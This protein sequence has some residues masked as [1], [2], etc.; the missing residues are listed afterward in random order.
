MSV[1]LYG[2]PQQDNKLGVIYSTGSI[3]IEAVIAKDIP[4][5]A[6]YAIFETADLD[7]QLFDA[8]RFSDG[9]P[10]FNPE[11][12]KE[13][14][15]DLWRQARAPLLASLDID[16]MRALESGDM[17]LQA[18]IAAKKQAL[19]DV[20]DTELPDTLEG[21]KAVWPEILGAR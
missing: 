16:F 1:I 9:G 19:R 10:D 13:I 11:K 12:G 14:W 15:R 8:Y 20:T 6:E 3:P 2:D 5:G 4:E 17:V 18:E 21:I 7:Y